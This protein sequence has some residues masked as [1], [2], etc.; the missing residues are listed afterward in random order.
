MRL[1]KV[2]GSGLLLVGLLFGAACAPSAQAAEAADLNRRLGRGVNLGNALEAP[3]EGDWGVRLESE[4]FRRVKEAGFQSVRLPVRWSAHAQAAVPY[5]IEEAFFQR[6]DWAMD[7][8]ARNGLAVVLNV[9]HYNELAADPAAHR[10]RYLALWRQIARRYANRPET[11]LF[12]PF[13]EPHD[14]LD[15]GLWNAL[16]PDV[17]AV[18]RESNPARV[19]VLGPASWNNVSK[20][21][22]LRL[23]TTDRRI[24]V[25]FH[26]Y[27]PF[28]FTHQ[29]AEWVGP[30]PPPLGRAWEGTASE[31]EAI[32]RDFDAAVTWAKAEGR[33]LYV[34]EFG[35]YEK[36]EMTSRARWTRAVREAAESRGMSWAYWEF[37][38]GFGA[39]DR[40]AGAWRA[41]L[42]EA[43]TR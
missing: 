40:Q 16:I 26:Y 32:A 6:V 30:N 2:A 12:E 20:L 28:P 41:P 10:E 5:A 37:V 27:N 23:P 25:T 22:T 36:A 19:V 14:K 1:A 24:I 38:S 33:P 34:G 31:R 42:L 8:A 15:E 3:R 17:L 39:F 9:H 21:P 11:V 35:S 7:E 29:G 43:L 4:Y 18:I 13:N